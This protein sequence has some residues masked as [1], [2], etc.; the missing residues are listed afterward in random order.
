MKQT[1]IY[2]T[3]KE[4]FKNSDQMQ[5]EHERQKSKESIKTR[6]N[7]QLKAVPGLDRFERA[8]I[9]AW[10]LLS[11]SQKQA[12]HFPKA[13]IWKSILKNEFQVYP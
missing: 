7:D 3:V 4:A 6:Q 11:Q 1:L 13:S 5:Q 9:R 10:N 2:I 12:K 8:Q